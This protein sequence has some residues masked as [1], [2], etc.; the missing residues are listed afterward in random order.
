M[1][2]IV[3]SN[4][5]TYSTV[6]LLGYESTI[7][8]AGVTTCTIISDDTLYSNAYKKYEY[9]IDN[10]L[11]FPDKVKFDIIHTKINKRATIVYL[12]APIV[13]IAIGT[14]F[15]LALYKKYG[16]RKLAND[17]SLK[18][19]IMVFLSL[20]WVRELLV[21]ILY[22]KLYFANKT[23]SCFIDEFLVLTINHLPLFPFLLLLG[24]IS[25]FIIGSIIF[26]FLP[27]NNRLVFLV[28]GLVGS[29]LGFIL[30]FLFLGPII[31]T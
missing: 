8:Y 2:G 18:D 13:T 19:W 31:M 15:F 25:T 21:F 27:K 3:V 20:F 22:V 16:K 12:A 14:V 5:S 28:S 4:F 24:S 17:L 30:W 29:F 11:S 1:V 6:R 23:D 26:V 10:G 9:E 7:G